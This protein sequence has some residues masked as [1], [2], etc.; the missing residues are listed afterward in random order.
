MAITHQH[1]VE[2]D[3]E[4]HHEHEGNSMGFM[5]GI[6]LLIVVLFLFVYYLFPAIRGSG[7]Q[8]NIPGKID[9]NIHQTK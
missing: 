5:M 8:F 6:L 7:T 9:V 2:V 1:E 4:I 3:H